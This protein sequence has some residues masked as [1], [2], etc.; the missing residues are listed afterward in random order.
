[1]LMIQE[2]H[3]YFDHVLN[4]ICDYIFIYDHMYRYISVCMCVYIYIL[5]SVGFSDQWD[6]YLF[7]SLIK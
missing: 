3:H 7:E 5:T 2:N 4:S 1:M 6:F